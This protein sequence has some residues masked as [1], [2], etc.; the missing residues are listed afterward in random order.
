M[1]SVEPVEHVIAALDG[2]VGLVKCKS[3]RSG[4]GAPSDAGQAGATIHS[5]A[6]HC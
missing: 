6:S 1:L 2:D 3:R 5:G 4:E